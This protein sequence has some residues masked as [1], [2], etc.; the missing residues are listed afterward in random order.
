MCT[1]ICI[2]PSNF[3]VTPTMGP[4]NTTWA[5]RESTCQGTVLPLHRS[6]IPLNCVSWR[7]RPIACSLGNLQ[8]LLLEHSRCP[9]KC[10]HELMTQVSYLI[11]CLFI[12]PNYWLLPILKGQRISTTGGKKK[13][14]KGWMALKATANKN[15]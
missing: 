13:K 7:A 3:I 5:S 10:L 1:T 14:K 12:R 9:S 2:F 15:F 11:L 4:S 8:S 6:F